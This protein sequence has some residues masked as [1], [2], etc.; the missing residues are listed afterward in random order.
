MRYDDNRCE[1]RV[2]DIFKLS[3]SFWPIMYLSVP[4]FNTTV[5]ACKVLFLILKRD[6]GLFFKIYVPNFQNLCSKFSKFIFRIFKIYVSN[7]QNLCSEF[8]KFMVRTFK[9]S[10]PNF[11][12]LCS[13]F[14]KAMSRFPKVIFRISEKFCSEKSPPSLD[15]FLCPRLDEKMPWTKTDPVWSNIA[16]SCMLRGAVYGFQ[17]KSQFPLIV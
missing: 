4:N 10:A 7:F 13:E 1:H 3:H 5:S 15:G 8:S 16:P 17:K 9:I 2:G 14:P 11:Q 12:N 6:F